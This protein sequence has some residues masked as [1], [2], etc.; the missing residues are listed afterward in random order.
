MLP[1]QGQAAICTS[2][3]LVPSAKPEVMVDELVDTEVE[4]VE[5]VMVVVV[6][7]VEVAVTVVLVV[8]LVVLTTA[9]VG[10]SIENS[11]PAAV[12]TVTSTVP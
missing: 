12:S 10:Y 3:A 6:A 4:V 5:L 1:D 8:T 2:N 11:F 9:L 7:V